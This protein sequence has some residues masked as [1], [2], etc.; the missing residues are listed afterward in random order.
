MQINK[1]SGHHSFHRSKENK[2]EAQNW[3]LLKLAATQCSYDNFLWY[4]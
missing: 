1:I 4:V 3:L 2:A